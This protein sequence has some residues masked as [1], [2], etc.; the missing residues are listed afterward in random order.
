MWK[1]T[2]R[3]IDAKVKEHCQQI[4]LEYAARSAVAENKTLPFFS[5]HDLALSGHTYS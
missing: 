2:D 4:R 5:R 3:S 1:Q